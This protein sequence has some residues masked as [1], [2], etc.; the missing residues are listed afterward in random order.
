MKPSAAEFWSFSLDVYNVPGVKDMCLTAQD[1]YG[2]DV[3]LLL[4]LAWHDREGLALSANSLSA[5]QAISRQWQ[6][7]TLAPHRAR[8]R[9]AKGTADYATLLEDELQLEKAAQ[10]ALLDATEDARRETQP[11]N[12]LRYVQRLGAPHSVIAPLLGAIRRS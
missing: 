12:C 10:A 4:L 7:N 3:N 11:D 8:R 5:L 1:R 6:E 2:A 9:A